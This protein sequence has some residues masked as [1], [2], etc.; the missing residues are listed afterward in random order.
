M[1]W[2]C[3]DTRNHKQPT[4]CFIVGIVTAFC[5][6]V[7]KTNRYVQ[8]DV[9]VPAEKRIIWAVIGLVKWLT[10]YENEIMYSIIYF[11]RFLQTESIASIF[12][13]L[14]HKHFCFVYF[15][16]YTLHPRLPVTYNNSS[17]HLHIL[18]FYYPTVSGS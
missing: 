6:L 8:N 15:F 4:N 13:S 5:K 9:Q 17:T 11:L 7:P 18:L 3:F 16:L 2:T 1:T 14:F 12:A 10:E